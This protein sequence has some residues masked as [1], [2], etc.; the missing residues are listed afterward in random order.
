[1]GPCSTLEGA[2]VALHCTE[3]VRPH[4]ALFQHGTLL[5]TSHVHLGRRSALCT[6]LQLRAC[7][8]LCL[9]HVCLLLDNTA[10]L[11]IHNFPSLNS[12][13]HVHVCAHACCMHHRCNLLHHIACDLQSL[14]LQNLPFPGNSCQVFQSCTHLCWSDLHACACAHTMC[15]WNNNISW[16]FS[17]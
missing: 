6:P 2:H 9:L 13:L 7:G 17:L 4:A 5:W 3:H 12:D 14:S 16:R 15:S 1:M 11:L 8:L 10:D